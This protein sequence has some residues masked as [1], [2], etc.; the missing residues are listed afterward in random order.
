MAMRKG[1]VGSGMGLRS[2]VV[3]HSK[4]V[5]DIKVLALSKSFRDVCSKYKG[6]NAEVKS[7]ESGVITRECI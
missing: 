2:V 7:Q 4:R 3:L 6:R 5:H 1:M